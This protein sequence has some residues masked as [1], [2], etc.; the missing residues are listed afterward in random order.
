MRI[1]S[2]HQDGSTR[3]SGHRPRAARLY[4]LL[5]AVLAAAPAFSFNFE[6]ISQSFTP[7][8][9]GATRSF[10][11]T[12]TGDRDIAVKITMVTRQVNEKGQESYAPASDLF[13]VFPSQI[14]LRGGA[15]QTVRVRW[16]GPADIRSE[17][18]FRIVAA[19]LPVDFGST[20]HEGGSIN[21][22][23]RYL[24]SVYITPSGARPDLVATAESGT[25]PGGERGLLVTFRNRGTA[26][27]ILNNLTMTVTGSSA[28]GLPVTRT[29]DSAALKG[30]D[31]ANVLAGMQRRFFLPV[32]GALPA[33]DL[34][35]EFSTH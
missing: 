27:A 21:I 16:T 32:T 3:W 24:G 20:Q 22:L 15:T 33:K 34:H 11:V 5:F 14:V 18:A 29:F 30:I 9:A 17:R 26:H 28:D 2:T 19:Q 4:V 23:F 13:V 6:P 7:T 10:V 12:N 25:G 31:G 35:V 8:G 1:R